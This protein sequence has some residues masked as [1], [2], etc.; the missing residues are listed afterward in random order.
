MS[1]VSRLVLLF[2][3]AF[4]ITA[5]ADTITLGGTITQSTQD[6]TGP[7]ANNP[8]LN[9]IATGDAYLLTLNFAGSIT[10]PG[11]YNLTGF[12]LLFEDPSAGAAENAF[13]SVNWTVTPSGSLYQISMLACLTTGAA[14]CAAS[15]QLTLDFGIPLAGLN[16]QNVTAQ[17]LPL[18][19]PFDLLEDDGVTDIHGSVTTYSY[20]GVTAVP[21]PGSLLLLGSGVIGV[22]AQRRKIL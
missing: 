18:L 6:G 12:N 17:G 9:A 15:N 20:T 8:G 14:G 21:E 4:P 13:S 5:V 11:S 19:Q 3:L 10:A 22:L 2:F 16:Q 1:A 7:A